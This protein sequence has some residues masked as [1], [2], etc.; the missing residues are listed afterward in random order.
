MVVLRTINL[1]FLA[2]AAL[3]ILV[4]YGG[5]YFFGTPNH[6][7]EGSGVPNFYLFYVGV[8]FILLFEIMFG[9]KMVIVFA[10]LYAFQI[11][12]VL[13]LVFLEP[14]PKL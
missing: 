12:M 5:E 9:K 11:W 14:K 6:F 10:F 8:L 1:F 4:C 2:C 7:S 3:H 13:P